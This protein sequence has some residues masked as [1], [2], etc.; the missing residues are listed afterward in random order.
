MEFTL[1]LEFV[2]SSGEVLRT[3]SYKVV[4]RTVIPVYLIPRVADDVE[5]DAVD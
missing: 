3:E 2:D 4:I 1:H 5:K